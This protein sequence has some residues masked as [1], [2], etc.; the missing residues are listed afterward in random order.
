MTIL[1]DFIQHGTVD[2]DLYFCSSIHWH[3]LFVGWYAV[4]NLSFMPIN[5]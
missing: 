2:T 4:D 5:L 3:H 1:V